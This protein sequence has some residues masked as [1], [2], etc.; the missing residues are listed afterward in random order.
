MHCSMTCA[1]Q[2]KTEAHDSPR[3][4][5]AVPDCTG[6]TEDNEL[7]DNAVYSYM[8]YLFKVSNHWRFVE[9][10]LY[11]RSQPLPELGI[12]YINDDEG[13]IRQFGTLSDWIRVGEILSYHH[14]AI[15]VFNLA[16]KKTFILENGKQ[17]SRAAPKSALRFLRSSPTG[18][19]L[20][21]S[22]DEA[23]AFAH[24]EAWWSVDELKPLKKHIVRDKVVMAVIRSNTHVEYWWP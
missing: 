6:G 18:I 21:V 14:E 15:V 5:E 7:K 4:V 9:E 11:I 1:N 17:P 10:G 16:E 13:D 20:L 19:G 2:L 22:G 8:E 24:I 23:Q 3:A 12:C